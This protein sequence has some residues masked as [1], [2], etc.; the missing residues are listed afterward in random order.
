ML[1]ARNAAVASASQVTGS[2]PL[3]DLV[4]DSLKQGELQRKDPIWIWKDSF[5]LKVVI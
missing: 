4:H 3:H 2:V 1:V 5:L